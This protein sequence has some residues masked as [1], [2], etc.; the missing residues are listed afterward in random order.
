MRRFLA[1][2]DNLPIN[3][4]AGKKRRNINMGSM[5]WHSL[6]A[7]CISSNKGRGESMC[8]PLSYIQNL[9]HYTDRRV[10]GGIREQTRAYKS[11]R[12][13]WLWKSLEEK[14]Y[15]RYHRRLYM[16]WS[17]QERIF[18]VT[19][20]HSCGFQSYHCISIYLGV[21]SRVTDSLFSGPAIH[22][23]FYKYVR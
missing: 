20:S 12:Y 8:L 3:S 13:D 9:Y 4:P 15:S 7:Y 17:V 23:D 1:D 5:R 11:A 21:L 2:G 10:I 16:L 14:L 22:T 6:G 19:T 18:G